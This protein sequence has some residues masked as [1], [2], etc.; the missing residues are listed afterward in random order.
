MEDQAVLLNNISVDD[1]GKAEATL[2]KFIH[3]RQAAVDLLQ[4]LTVAK[5]IYIAVI[6]KKNELAQTNDELIKLR[7]D[8]EV[9]RSDWD[10]HQAAL[11]KKYSYAEEKLSK[12]YE[13]LSS[14]TAEKKEA[15]NQ[16]TLKEQTKLAILQDK[17][18]NESSKLDRLLSAAQKEFIQ[19]EEKRNPVL[20]DLKK[21]MDGIQSAS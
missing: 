13:K 19:L 3:E 18:K 14:E 20:A 5:D 2:Q 12:D 11:R 7:G 21:V 1:I 8:I 6:K 4:V 15:L 17:V 10:K 9:E 16:E